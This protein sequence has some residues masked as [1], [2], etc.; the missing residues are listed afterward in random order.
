[1][2]FL[3]LCVDPPLV[4]MF[5][6]EIGIDKGLYW[7]YY[8]VPTGELQVHHTLKNRSA[9]PSSFSVLDIEK[10]KITKDISKGIY[11][12]RSARP[13]F[14]I[15]NHQ[16]IS[17]VSALAFFICCVVKPLLFIDV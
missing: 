2:M 16:F 12:K 9:I 17:Y 15:C 14:I 10:Y 4:K 8:C 3:I 11:K 7:K 1:M 5:D 13:Y 6:K